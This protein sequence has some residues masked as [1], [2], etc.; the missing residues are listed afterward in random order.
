MKFYDAHS[1]CVK[2]Q[3]GGILL[4]MEGKPFFEGTLTNQEVEN[5]V[6]EN[7]Q[8]LPAYYISS[9]M[10]AVPD[11]RILKYHPRREHYSP[12]EVIADLKKRHCK[13]CI[14]DTLNQPY[15]QALDYWKVIKAFP[16]IY[17]I[18][19]HAGGYDIVD[20]LKILDFNKNV[21]MDFSMTQEYFGWCGTR[22]RLGVVA[23]GIDYCLN[24]DKLSKRILFGSDEPFF[25]QELALEKYLTYDSAE[26]ILV[27]NY[28]E[29][30]SK[31]G[32]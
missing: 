18:F 7:P 8:F 17:F 6:R 5:I 11:E 31:V 25:S 15:W 2:N 22:S 4:G 20:F 23:D 27:N 29:L 21:Y 28:L 14:I 24:S 10:N 1:H 12:E 30:I 13:L 9:E 32:L 19:P 16:E 26:D 3:P